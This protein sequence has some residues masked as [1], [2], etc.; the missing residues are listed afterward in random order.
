M[1]VCLCVCVNICVCIYAGRHYASEFIQ[2]EVIH[3]LLIFI[4]NAICINSK[5]IKKQNL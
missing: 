2:N 3:H 4:S 5:F 1:Y